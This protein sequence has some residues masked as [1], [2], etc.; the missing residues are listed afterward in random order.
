MAINMMCMNS[1]C[2]YWFEDCCT[3]NINEERTIIDENGKC[4]T[5]EEGTSEWYKLIEQEEFKML[6][7]GVKV[8]EI[9]PVVY[10]KDK[11]VESWKDNEK[12]VSEKMLEIGFENFGVENP[13]NDLVYIYFQNRNWSIETG[14][15]E[16]YEKLT[17]IFDEVKINIHLDD[18]IEGLGNSIDLTLNEFKVELI[19]SIHGKVIDYECDGDICHSVI[20]PIDNEV[21]KV[22][23]ELGKS[24]KW[25]E[26]NMEHEDGGD[27]IDLTLI[28]FEFADWWDSEE[29][30]SEPKEEK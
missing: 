5:F 29:G 23:K 27:V 25:I 24:D 4:E 2:K 10:I 7:K 1:K 13:I 18:F 16:T 6:Y 26:G 8:L 14:L 12:Y 17:K 3:R 19:N 28:G 15:S 20:C 9:N 21:V 30:F 22:M 11:A